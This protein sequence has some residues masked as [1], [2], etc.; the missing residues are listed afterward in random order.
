MTEDV[1]RV[2]QALS[3]RFFGKYRGEVTDTND[4]TNR[5]R[6]KVKCPAVLGEQEV[7]AM[8]A[9]PY[10]G[11]GIGLFA[12]PAA[13]NRV[14]VALDWALAATIPAQDVQIGSI[15]AEAA[16]I[17]TAQHTDRYTVD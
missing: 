4:S 15:P 6:L 16:L 10:S 3:Q 12:L 17:A 2:V 14:R 8:P 1:D 11:D 7:W 13:S 5:A 9:V